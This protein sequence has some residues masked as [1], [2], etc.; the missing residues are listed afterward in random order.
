M[1]HIQQF[2]NDVNVSINKLASTYKV[3]LDEEIEKLFDEF[4]KRNKAMTELG[5]SMLIDKCWQL[6]DESMNAKLSAVKQISEKPY[7]DKDEFE[8]IHSVNKDS[9]MRKV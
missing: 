9:S 8:R 6:Y 2:D 5:Q 4:N 3:M 1:F 7:Y